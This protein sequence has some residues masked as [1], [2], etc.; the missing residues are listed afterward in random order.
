MTKSSRF[1]KGVMQQYPSAMEALDIGN[2]K[3]SVVHS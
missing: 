3:P 1:S 2:S